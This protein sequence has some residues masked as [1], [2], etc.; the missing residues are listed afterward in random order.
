MKE[1]K[2]RKEDLKG[3]SF[4]DVLGNGYPEGTSEKKKENTAQVKAFWSCIPAEPGDW[5]PDQAY[6][7]ISSDY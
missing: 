3:S 6:D 7:K 2:C 1:K 5:I 4:G